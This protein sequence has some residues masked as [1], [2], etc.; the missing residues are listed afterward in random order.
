MPL[1]ADVYEQLRDTLERFVR[2]RLV[3]IEDK[4]A[5]DDAM[6]PE[7][8]AEMRDMGPFGMSIPQDY[9]GMGLTMEEEV[10]MAF[11][12]GKTSPAFRS[13]IGTNNGS[14]TKSNV[15]SKCSII[16]NSCNICM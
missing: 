13:L 7:I 1:D 5:E 12:L 16:C 3:P 2:E 9:G 8:V 6:P 15:C 4:V 14:C 11:E 10:G